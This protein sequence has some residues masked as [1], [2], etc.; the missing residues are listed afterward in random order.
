M[1]GDI[2]SWQEAWSVVA[3]INDLQ[4]KLL[5]T[6]SATRWTKLDT[7]WAEVLNSDPL[8]Y[9]F[10]EPIVDRLARR[11][12]P[13]HLVR[14][15][16]PAIDAMLEKGAGDTAF[17]V[18]EHL[19]GIDERHEWAR[20]RLIQSIRSVYTDQIG[21]RIDEFIAQSGLES[22][23]V[24]LRKAL[25]RLTDMLGATR[26]QVFRHQSWGLGVV[27]D[28][29]LQTGRVVIDFVT[30]KSQPMT[31]DGVRNFLIRIPK[32]HLQARIIVE[33]EV[34]REKL[35]SEPQEII[36]LALRHT[37]NGRLKVSELKK[38]LT[39]HFLT[40]NEYK[41]FW[42]RA[43][44]A[45][46][47]DPW[48]DQVGSGANAEFVLRE[49]ARSF[50]EEIFTQLITAK[51]ASARREALRDVRRHGSD[52]EMTDQ[53]AEALFGLFTK[54][55][56]DGILRTDSEKLNHGLIFLEYCDLFPSKTNPIDV[57]PLLAGPNVVDLLKTLEDHEIRCLALERLIDLRP[58]EWADIFAEV[59]I[60]MDSRTAAWM[61]KELK[62]RGMEHQRQ[63]AL[64]SILAK[65]DSNPDLFVWAARNL[66]EGNW[67]HLHD[68]I[69]PTMICEE[70]LSLLAELEEDFE[71]PNTERA[72]LARNAATKI[73]AVLNEGNSRFFKRAIVS[74]NVEEARRILQAIR[75][76]DALSHQLKS[77]LENILINQHEDLRRVSRMEEE[78]E[79]K[80]PAFH[81]TTRRSLDEKRTQLSRLLSQEIPAMAKVIEAA[82]E[83]GDLRENSEYHAAKDRQK[84]LMQQAAELEDLI[85]R[86]R[87][88]EE[89]EIEPD[90]SRFGTRL[91]IR[92]VVSSEVKEITVLGM[93]EAD[94]SRS[95]IS[96]LTPF[97]SQLLGRRVGENFD[98]VLQDGTKQTFE[99][100]DIAIALPP[101][102]GG[103]S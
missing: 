37:P 80:K 43:K 94:M 7:E 85:A 4:Q 90:N 22:E 54:P 21:T 98:V 8:P 75:L 47:V 49:T 88:V 92:D 2:V 55:L 6:I 72:T 31:L 84:L 29:D 68:V 83:M 97:G 5:S 23:G 32:D 19:I 89:K 66:L 18:L 79:R 27:K 39:T 58:D 93:W 9:S 50:F 99:L 24:S 48:I 15:Y 3:E 102:G 51:T 10:H 38:T 13:E 63:E 70:L 62:R 96:Y 25:Q 45:I 44:K 71:S 65:P 103:V 42:E 26:G 77:Q 33:P 41:S 1:K 69:P 78:E 35:R 28:L 30:K 81:Y 12:D 34:L 14:L 20:P 61:E 76:H 40:E 52:A 11:Q 60:F 36:R 57:D 87:V 95:I 100:L 73:R 53:D 86:A 46:K 17:E 91:R 16:Q 64:E 67:D 101:A 82:R 74:S 56:T 59:T